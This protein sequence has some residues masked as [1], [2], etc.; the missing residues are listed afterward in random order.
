M[1]LSLST[2]PS[3]SYKPLSELHI[4]SRGNL[5]MSWLMNKGR[6]LA[7]HNY[8]NEPALYSLEISSQSKGNT[9]IL[10]KGDSKKEAMISQATETASSGAF[11]INGPLGQETME[12]GGK[13]VY[14]W[15]VSAALCSPKLPPYEKEDTDKKT[16]FQWIRTPRVEGKT[17]T[18]ASPDWKLHDK[19]SGEVHAVFVENWDGTTDR[20][21][22]QFR[23]SFGENWE[24]GVLVSVGIVAER[25]RAR[26]D[27][28]GN[29]TKGFL[30]W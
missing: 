14:L 28:R 26:R 23:R 2:S 4:L 17:A 27:R 13:D 21:Q 8:K 16:T 1:D 6:N 24:M 15:T 29:F 5:G 20:G 22:I 19:E 11:L 7:F 25:E 10:R 3:P 12:R 9:V 30:M 18:F